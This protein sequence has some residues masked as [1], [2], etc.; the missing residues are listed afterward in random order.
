MRLVV[1]ESPYAGAYDVNLM[2][3]RACLR[4]SLDRGESPIAG[5]GLLTQVLDDRKAE[6]RALGI[7]CHMAWIPMA[8]AVAAYTDLGVS[9]GMREAITYAESIGVPVERRTLPPGRLR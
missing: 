3:L 4:D 5:H 1:I 2:Y 7:A 8:H 9:A 6:E